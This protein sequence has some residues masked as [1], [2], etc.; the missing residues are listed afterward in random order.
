MFSFTHGKDPIL[1]VA[2]CDREAQRATLDTKTYTLT[3]TR[4]RSRLRLANI[5]PIKSA[6]ASQYQIR[7][8]KDSDSFAVHELI[9]H[10]FGSANYQGRPFDAWLNSAKSDTFDPSFWRLAYNEGCLI[11]AALG[12]VQGTDSAVT[13]LAVALN[14]RRSGLG[15]ALLFNLLNRFMQVGT[16]QTW[17][18]Y[19]LPEGT[20]AALLYKQ[21][22]F[23]PYGQVLLYSGTVHGR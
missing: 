6:G 11:G 21:V 5:P 19:S 4:I 3:G 1:H 7:S 8:Y 12:R 14:H 17:L 13:H 23:V 15:R 16:H 22:G 9:Q 18:D 10:S 20:P 2:A